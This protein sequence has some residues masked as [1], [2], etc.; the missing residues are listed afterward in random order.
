MSLVWNEKKKKNVVEGLTDRALVLY[1]FG[2]ES[3]NRELLA[4]YGRAS[5]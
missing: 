4:Q 3:A 1:D 2:P 5:E